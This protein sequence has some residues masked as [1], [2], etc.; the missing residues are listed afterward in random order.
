MNGRL[1]RFDIQWRPRLC[2]V[3]AGTI[4]VLSQYI[5]AGPPPGREEVAARDTAAVL[6]E[7]DNGEAGTALD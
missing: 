1:D 6:A 4:F 5:A 2:F 7:T 3:L